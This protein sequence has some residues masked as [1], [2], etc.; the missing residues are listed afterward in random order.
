MASQASQAEPLGFVGRN[1]SA[2]QIPWQ[3]H[4]QGPGGLQGA[5]EQR[6][7][8]GQEQAQLCP[9]PSTWEQ[10]WGHRQRR[11]SS[12]PGSHIIFQEPHVRQRS[13]IWGLLFFS[14]S[15]KMSVCQSNSSVCIVSHLYAAHRQNVKK[16]IALE[17]K[18]MRERR[19]HEP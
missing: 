10:P 1:T 4:E 18:S 19:R 2:P 9:A 11:D 12:W 17:N 6:Q 13:L 16:K 7:A 8:P 15:H 3:D 5:V 14:Q